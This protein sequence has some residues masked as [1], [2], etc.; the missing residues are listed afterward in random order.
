PV[1]LTQDNVD[2]GWAAKALLA[3]VAARIGATE[4]DND[5]QL[6]KKLQD[7]LRAHPPDPRLIGAFNRAFQERAAQATNAALLDGLRRFAGEAAHNRPAPT[8]ST[9]GGN[10][11]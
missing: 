10:S 9:A 4:H 7:F 3:R 8:A 2:D 5:A 11:V 1:L 6:Q